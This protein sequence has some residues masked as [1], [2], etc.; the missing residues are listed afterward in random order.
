MDADPLRDRR[1]GI[2]GEMPGDGILQPQPAGLHQRHDRH[3]GEHLVHRAVAKTGVERVGGA[4]LAVGLT[5]RGREDRCAVL[6][7]QHGAREAAGRGAAGHLG[8]EGRH[9]V[10]LVQGADVDGQAQAGLDFDR[11]DAVRV[12]GFDVDREPCPG[13]LGVPLLDEG[14]RARGRGAFDADEIEPAGALVEVEVLIDERPRSRRHELVEKP[15]PSGAIGGVEHGEPLRELPGRPSLRRRLRAQR[16]GGQGCNHTG[17]GAGHAGM[18][19]DSLH[20]ER[21]AP[22]AHRILNARKVRY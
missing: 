22:A 5:V 6:R 11:H 4:Q 16:H 15:L 14:D 20:D 8:A 10:G 1:V 9:Q 3:C 7:D 12:C 2:A 19:R 18:D 21:L 13:R 17:T